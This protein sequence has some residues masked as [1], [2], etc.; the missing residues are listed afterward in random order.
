M[1]CGRDGSPETLLFDR[2]EIA[3][4]SRWSAGGSVVAGVVDVFREAAGRSWAGSRGCPLE[5]SKYLQRLF[6]TE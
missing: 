1:R 6:Y 3:R 2:D 4:T 5:G